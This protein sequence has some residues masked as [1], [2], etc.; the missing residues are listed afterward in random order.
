MTVEIASFLVYLFSLLILIGDSQE[1]DYRNQIVN[2]N[3]LEKHKM[4]DLFLTF[5]VRSAYAGIPLGIYLLA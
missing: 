4:L 5:Y 1:C 2:E 3:I